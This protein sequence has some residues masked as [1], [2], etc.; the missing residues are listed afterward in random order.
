MDAIA[1]PLE[2]L[3]P[4]GNAAIPAVAE[5]RRRTWHTGP[6]GLRARLTEATRAH[7]EAWQ[8]VLHACD[9]M[10]EAPG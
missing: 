6:G 5:F 10:P 3:W 1:Q 9:L 2:A 4:G 7:A 8:R